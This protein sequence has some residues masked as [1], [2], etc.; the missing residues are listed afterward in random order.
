LRVFTLGS[1]LSPLVFSLLQHLQ[2][3][4]LASLAHVAAAAVSLL[5]TIL[6]AR[7]RLAAWGPKTVAFEFAQ[8]SCGQSLCCAAGMF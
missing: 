2:R 1:G 5:Q 6:Q 4:A 7:Q 3:S 8:V